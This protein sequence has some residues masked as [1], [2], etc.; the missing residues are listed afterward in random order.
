MPLVSHK[1]LLLA[2][3]TNHLIPIQARHILYGSDVDGLAIEGRHGVWRTAVVQDGR[4]QVN[5]CAYRVHVYV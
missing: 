2:Q 3:K 4:C 5:T 1:N